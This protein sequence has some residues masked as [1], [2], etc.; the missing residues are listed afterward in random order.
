VS[1]RVGEK[2]REGRHISE[3]ERKRGE[4]ESKEKERET[5]RERQR[6]GGYGMTNRTYEG[7]R[8]K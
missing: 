7:V 3:V 6:K 8:S 4:R 2:E 5:D 1:K